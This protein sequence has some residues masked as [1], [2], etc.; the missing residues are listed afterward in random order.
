MPSGSPSTGTQTRWASVVLLACVATA[1]N[2][3]RGCV[4]SSFELAPESRLPVWLRLSAGE[5]RQDV[6][7]DLYHYAPPSKS[8]DDV[9]L[10]VHDSSLLSH[11]VSGR[12][13]WH[14][15]TKQQL[16]KYWA[17]EPRPE[18]PKPTYIVIEIDGQIDVIEHR[19][20][21]EQN[22]DPTRALFWMSNDE[23]I[24][25][26]ARESRSHTKSLR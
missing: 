3:A 19:A 26:E 17:T 9:V 12:H 16:D 13:W 5:E 6:S 2:P 1:C 14:P 7:L 24:L 21:A 18:F 15:R 4:A 8:V 11:S 25:E 22:R 10:V 20:S 23:S